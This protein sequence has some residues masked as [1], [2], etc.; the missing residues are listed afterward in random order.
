MWVCVREIWRCNLNG[1]KVC[2]CVRE[3]E[4]ETDRQ[5]QRAR[6]RV[7]VRVNVCERGGDTASKGEIQ[8]P[9]VRGCA[10]V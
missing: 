3:R 4:R 5:R 7:R 6:E 9:R 1:E 8:H 2:V 10:R